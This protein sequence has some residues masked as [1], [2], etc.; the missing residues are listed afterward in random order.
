M[1]E[2]HEIG[3]PV[4]PR[5]FAGLEL[6]DQIRDDLADLEAP[7]PGARWVESDNLHITLRFAGDIDKR[8]A[9]E[10]TELLGS[11]EAH[12]FELRLVGLST[13]GSREPKAI[14]A[15]VENSAEL[16]TLQRATERAARGAG[17]K[18][19]TRN[20]KPHVTLARLQNPRIEALARYLQQHGA[21]RS[22]PFVISR[23][24]LFSSRPNVG[25]GPYVV[26]DA[27]PLSGAMWEA[28]DHEGG[29]DNSW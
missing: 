15:N 18:P 12:A 9:R 27:Y 21:Y 16:D 11:I 20:F 10:L 6:P 2:L 17:L 19:E 23:F 3:E 29:M 7:I 28:F 22:E 1:F 5:L 14:I 8:Q 4:M 25:G 24:V 26:E 13:I